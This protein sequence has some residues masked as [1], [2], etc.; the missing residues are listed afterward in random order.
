MADVRFMRTE[1][2]RVYGPS[3]VAGKPPRQIV[4][5]YNNMKSRGKFEEPEIQNDI[6]HQMN[7]FDWFREKGEHLELWE[8]K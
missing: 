1:I 3:F 4:A 6:Y 7:I 8:T 2:A 5:I